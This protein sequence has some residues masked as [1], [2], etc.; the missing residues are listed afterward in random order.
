MKMIN[1][2]RPL[3]R[4]VED[5]KGVNGACLVCRW[6]DACQTRKFMEE[7]FKIEMEMGM[8]LTMSKCPAYMGA[9]RDKFRS[10]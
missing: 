7:H 10:E 8:E 6:L 1:E 4:N 9:E 3:T 5:E 2:Q